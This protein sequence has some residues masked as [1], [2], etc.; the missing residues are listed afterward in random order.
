MVATIN[1]MV[2]ITKADNPQKRYVRFYFNSHEPNEPPRV[3][4]DRDQGSCNVLFT[5][6]ALSSSLGFRA[7]E[8]SEIERLVGLNRD[9]LLRAWEEFHGSPWRAGHR[10]CL[11]R[12]HAGRRF[13][14]WLAVVVVT[15]GQILMKI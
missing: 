5:L 10:G 1:V 14:R 12:G 2:V 9:I 15:T 13:G 6:V 7:S 8:L 3:H 11:H 4:V